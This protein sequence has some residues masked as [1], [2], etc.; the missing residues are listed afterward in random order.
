MCPRSVLKRVIEYELSCLFESSYNA[1]F[2]VGVESEFVLLKNTNPVEPVNVHGYSNSQ[3]L[4]SGTKETE[5][6]ED[7]A[8]G[9]VESGI[10]LMMYHSE[11]APGQYEVVTGPLPPLEAADALVHTRETI[12]NMASKHGFRATFAPRLYLDNCGS[13]AHTHISVHPINPEQPFGLQPSVAEDP[14]D[15]SATSENVLTPLEH[16]FLAGL[17]DHLPAAC[18][19]TLPNCTS[20]SRMVDGI[21][22]GGTWIAWGT[23]NRETPVRLCVP[24]TYPPAPTQTQPLSAKSAV[25]TANPPSGNHF[26]VK[27]VDGTSSPYLAFSGLLGA[28]LLGI[29]SR[30]PLIEKDCR[31]T[32]ATMTEAEREA[33]GVKRRLPRTWEEARSALEEDVAMRDLLGGVVEGFLTLDGLLHSPASEAERVQML[34][35]NY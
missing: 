24:P 4:A 17:L 11:A 29:Q 10:E 30:S 18:A 34:V 1:A 7:I 14:E 31:A 22:S 35:E 12:F 16:V 6:M 9:L 15:L 8:Q 21:W 5:V 2:L 28:G 32:A 13:A 33:V 27:C 25:P 3:A 20:Y 26:E 23:H 19:F